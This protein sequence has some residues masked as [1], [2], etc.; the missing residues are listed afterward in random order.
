MK[1]DAFYSYAEL[2]EALDDLARRY[3]RWVR[4]S[5]LAQTPEGRQVWIATLADYNLSNAEDKPAYWIQANIHAQEACGTNVALLFMEKL[6][7]APDVLSR[8]IYYIVPRVN[9]DGAERSI[10]HRDSTIRSRCIRRNVP[11]ALVPQDIDGDGKVAHMRRVN[12]MGRW[13]ALPGPRE[14]M[15]PREPGDIE[16]TF[17]D[18][19]D[20]GIIENW[21]EGSV[22]SGER[23]IDLNRSY[24]VNWEPLAIATDYPGQAPE[25]RGILD[26][27]TSHPNIYAGVD[28]H[29]GTSGILRPTSRTNSEL[30]R[31]DRKLMQMIAAQASEITGFQ[32][33]F[34]I[35]YGTVPGEKPPKLP[36]GACDFWYEV[37]GLSH[38]TV[39]L[40]NG[41]NSIGM[42]SLEVLKHYGDLNGELLDRVED[43]HQAKGSTVH[44]P[45]KPFL[46]PQLGDVEVGG[47]IG[48]Q[49]Y[50]MY[51]PDM[52]TFAPKT[53]E[54]LRVHSEMV[55]R[56][57]AGSG[58]IDRIAENIWR[59]YMECMNVG[60]FGTQV[61]QGSPGHLGK[62]SARAC[63]YG[64]EI[65]NAEK[66]HTVPQLR[67]MEKTA[68]EWFVRAD[69]GT[70]ITVRI[71]H[72]KAEAAEVKMVLK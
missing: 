4:L 24:P 17:Y 55:A 33:F 44:L 48:G 27:L 10:M 56:F 23:S 25:T 47:M 61:M 40:G 69:P 58:R 51:L 7:S 26:F 38:Y 34:D 62:Q 30:N 41:Y 31:E 8:H 37:L 5:S 15:V 20:E 35:P 14:I 21:D 42:P 13:K 46:H 28:L 72:P 53:V 16:G 11:N 60:R 39:E 49:A 32:N 70:E 65:L 57:L 50:H 22:V 12:Q 19:W 36:G 18:L 63:L 45:W 29:N 52:E 43:F 54:F 1:L 68:L 2:T 67:S 71:T 64:A 3:P 59:V 66:E 6:L 9:P